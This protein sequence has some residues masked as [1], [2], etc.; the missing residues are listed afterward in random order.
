LLLLFIFTP[1]GLKRKLYRLKRE[2]EFS[3]DSL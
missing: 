2:V 3:A 1:Y